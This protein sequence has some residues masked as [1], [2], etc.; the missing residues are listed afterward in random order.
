MMNLT[1]RHSGGGA[2]KAV[3]LVTDVMRR[4]NLAD[5]YNVAIDPSRS[6]EPLDPGAVLNRRGHRGAARMAAASVGLRA[7]IEDASPD[8]IHVH[9]E[10]PELAY[11]LAT[12]L[13]PR[14]RRIPLVVTEHSM[15]SWSGLRRPLGRIV[16]VALKRSGALVLSCFPG[17]DSA[18]A[19]FP[20]P[21]AVP[22]VAC[23]DLG[24][25][26]VLV[27][28]RLIQSK[29]VDMVLRALGA[30]ASSV[31]VVVVGDGPD[32]VRLERLSADLG[33]EASFVGFDPNP[34][35]FGS[36]RDVF[37]T[38]SSLEGDPLTLGEAVG[39]NL[40]I[41]AS[42]IDP[43]RRLLGTEHAGLF[44]GADELVGL[45]RQGHQSGFSAFL[46]SRSAESRIADR[47]PEI[48]ARRLVRVYGRH[49]GI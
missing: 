9:C 29:R 2:E 31:P 7:E 30:V 47:S 5:V 17:S 3:Q 41:I 19:Y 45:L 39:A 6:G 27:I 1:I 4:E 28:G 11:V 14:L 38:A 15:G 49:C 37:V 24:V 18:A 32:R 10:A 23:G 8:V 43:H 42:S 48:V 26:R 34:W 40:P 46:P 36:S 20:N 12:V 35:R 25:T 33:V 16:R 44:E 21:I 22:E 13:T